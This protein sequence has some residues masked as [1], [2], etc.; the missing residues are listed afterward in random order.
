V[1]KLSPLM[2]AGLK[3]LQQAGG[4]LMYYDY[5]KRYNAHTGAALVQRGLVKVERREDP[6]E[7]TRPYHVLTDLGRQALDGAAPPTPATPT[8]PSLA[9]VRR[10]E[11]LSLAAGPRRHLLHGLPR[12]PRPPG[13]H[14]GRVM[15]RMSKQFRVQRHRAK[16]RQK[17][18]AQVLS[19]PT[20]ICDD[21]KAGRH[22]ECSTLPEFT[23]KYGCA[24]ALKGHALKK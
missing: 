4:A 13:R 12:E 20:W 10:P 16:L 18:M 14:R 7:V 19:D 15:A 6:D 22:P 9:P 23:T 3:M 2:I 1:K 24:C 8:P 17:P 11:R 21:C 5:R